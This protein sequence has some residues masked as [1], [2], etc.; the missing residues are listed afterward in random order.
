MGERS[1]F[2]N[3]LLPLPSF[4]CY[5]TSQWRL[6]LLNL[7][8]SVGFQCL[9]QRV[10]ETM[11]LCICVCTHVCVDELVNSCMIMLLCVY[12]WLYPHA[13][14][15]SLF[16]V[17]WHD[18]KLTFFVLNKVGNLYE[19]DMWNLSNCSQSRMKHAISVTLRIAYF[20]SAC[21]CCHF[22]SLNEKKRK[23]TKAHCCFHV[24]WEKVGILY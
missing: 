1:I 19:T 7:K 17:P 16:A 2:S 9:W 8:W 15:P 14:P 4:R 5:Q 12:E 20:W 24:K 11:C 18:G 10:D 3:T 22:W 6:N 23:C 21:L 13:H